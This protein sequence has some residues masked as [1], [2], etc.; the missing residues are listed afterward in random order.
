MPLSAWLA[1]PGTWLASYPLYVVT[2]TLAALHFDQV[3]SWV[4]EHRRAVG[5]GSIVV[6]AL[7]VVSYQA[8]IHL[9]GMS[10]LHTSEVFAP[11]VVAESM[12]VIAAQ[13]ALGLWVAEH[14]GTRSRRW[15]R[16]SAEVSFGV[17]L[18][19]PLLYQ[20]LLA[21]LDAVGWRKGLRNLPAGVGLTVVLVVIVP[22]IYVLAAPGAGLAR[23]TPLSMALTGR[24]CRPGR[25]RPC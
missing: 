15:L 1:H 20:G 23:R 5:S 10:P 3:R 9:V 25:D 12:A 18:A 22:G 24:R 2:G 13:L 8:D 4:G 17:Y 21:A 11:A 7:S 14:A 19:H 6:V 16:T